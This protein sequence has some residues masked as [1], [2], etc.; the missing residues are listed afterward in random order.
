M[1]G[2]VEMNGLEVPEG[3][4]HKAS[5]HW[6]PEVSAVTSENK[7]SRGGAGVAVW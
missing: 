6:E 1:V 5:Q 7:K 3:R 2:G 4:K